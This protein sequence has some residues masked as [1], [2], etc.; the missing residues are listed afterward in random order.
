MNAKT[1]KNIKSILMVALF[2]YLIAVPM[3]LLFVIGEAKHDLDGEKDYALPAF[4]FGEFLNRK[5]Q[6][7]F[8]NWFSTKYPLRPEFVEAYGMIDAKKDSINLNFIKSAPPAPPAVLKD[9]TGNETADSEKEK[10][11]QTIEIEEIA[12]IEPKFPEY[13]LPPE[14]LYDPDGYR[15]TDHVIIGKNGCLYENGYIN[16]YYGYSQKYVNVTDDQLIYRAETLRLI[17]D[18][19]A[20]RGIA[21]CVAISPSKASNMPDHIPDWYIAQNT[22]I[23]PDYVR[24]YVRFVKFLKEKGVY[25]VD[26]SSLYKSLG[27]TNTFPK[28]GIH[29]NRMAAYET[30][31]A[32]IDEYERQTGAEVKHLAADGI[33]YSKNPPGAEKDIFG[34]VYA[35]KKKEMENAIVDDRYYWPDVYTKNKS[36]PS[37]PHMTVQGG[38]FTGDFA[39][40]F[41]SYNIVSQYTG[42]YYNDGGNVKKKWEREIGKTSYV[43]LEVNEQFVYNMGGNAPSWGQNDIVILD[44][45]PNIVDSLYDYLLDNPY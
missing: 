27:M 28:T 40:Y 11:D 9:D 3:I 29:W 1:A 42:Y 10:E 22:P 13:I 19:L 39:Y 2:A 33:R 34:I 45:G 4:H 41:Q 20:K 17:Q 35:G 5:F 37:I 8:E 21:F 32:L 36:N 12:V 18:E 44:L 26:S 24:P 7:D 14:D 25:F 31:V 16:E 6:T 43:I 38:S 23:K 15:G 30:C